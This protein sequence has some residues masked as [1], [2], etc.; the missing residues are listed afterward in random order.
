MACL[1]S[2]VLSLIL[3]IPAIT[4]ALRCGSD[5]VL[6]GDRKIEVLKACGDPEF[7]EEWEEE[8]VT[9]V[10]DETDKISGDLIIGRRTQIGKSNILRIEE[11]TYN[12]GSRSFMQ[13]LTFVNG[14][15]KKIE[16]G[17]RGTYREALSGSS[18][19]RCSDLIEKGDRKIEVIMNCGD[20]YS[21][22]YFWEEQFSAVSSAIRIRKVPQFKRKRDRYKKEY[23][24]I[25]E[26]IYEQ[27]RRLI[28]IEE[29]TYNF[30]PGRFMNFIQFQNGKVKKVEY[31][32]YGF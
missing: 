23:T 15:L 1:T 11:W 22:E 4:F 24:F 19:S 3:F 31:G 30:G 18:Q 6:K 12:F 8:T 14:K 10:T 21:I 32:D 7:I 5:L 20:P 17:P 16:D 2:S 26:K 27:S 29:W 25:R 9:H 28:N 13:Y